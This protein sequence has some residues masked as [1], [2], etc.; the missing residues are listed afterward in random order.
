MISVVGQV[1]PTP[2]WTLGFKWRAHSGRPYTAVVGR[3]DVSAYVDG[4]RWIP[5]LGSYDGA[6][7]PWYHRLDVRGERAFRIGNARA[8]AS[9][10]LINVYGRKNL[11]DYRYVDGYS[12]AQPVGMLPFLP[13]FGMTVAF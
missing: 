7:F 10:E 12:R 1:H 6:R 9:L 8:S 4:V 11:F 2:D 3:E 5:V 13:T